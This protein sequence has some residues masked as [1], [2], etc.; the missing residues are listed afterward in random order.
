M[1]L[2]FPVKMFS[3]VASLP[4]DPEVRSAPL[5]RLVRLSFIFSF[6][7]RLALVIDH[8]ARA[9]GVTCIIQHGEL[10]FEVFELSL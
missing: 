2:I 9:S 5:G 3:D 10:V 6:E 4:V 1:A 7:I 8:G